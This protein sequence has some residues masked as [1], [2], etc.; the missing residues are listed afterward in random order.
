MI[1]FDKTKQGFP[2]DSSTYLVL[3]YKSGLPRSFWEIGVV[4][5]KL[6][7]FKIHQSK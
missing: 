6:N 1:E 2:Y 4:G 3:Y 5:I 7:L